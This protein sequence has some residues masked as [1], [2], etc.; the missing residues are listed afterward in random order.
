MPDQTTLR[1]LARGQTRD[2]LNTPAFR[3]MPLDDQREMFRNVYARNYRTLAEAHSNGAARSAAMAQRASDLID[4]Q[5][6]LNKRI[7]QA[8]EMAG[9]FIN[10]VNFPKFVR[11][12]LKGVFDA[13]LQVTL[14]QMESYQKLLKAATGSITKFA[15]AVKPESAFG[16][17]AENNSDEF[18]INF[19]DTEKD[20]EG[21]RKVILTDKDG[22][23]VDHEDASV[24][25]KI[26]DATI[27][28]A[29]EQRALLRETILMGITRLVVEKGNVK[30]SV[31]FDVK[32]QEHI[33]KGDQ[34][35]IKEA[36]SN[37]SSISASG[38]FLGSIFGGPQGGHTSSYRKTSISISTTKSQ[39]DTELQAK[40]MGSVDITFKSDYFKL[41]N[42]ATMYGP[43]AAGGAAGGPAQSGGPGAAAPAPGAPALTPPPGG[44]AR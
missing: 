7:D 15:Q 2:A 9:D 43:L 5:R 16:Y 1:E 4:D 12:L 19:S 23:A 13:N 35:A 40:V 27:Q 42:F 10:Q 22:Q 11:E 31:V 8:G 36:V 41:D 6:H 25:A 39:S 30:A 33:Q 28:M 34:A 37:S 21:N 3:T 17:L 32:A 44:G 20:E 38:G 18:G 26:M 29:R 24:K 14:Q